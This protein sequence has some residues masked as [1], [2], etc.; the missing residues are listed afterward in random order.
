MARANQLFLKI[1]AGLQPP[2]SGLVDMSKETTMGYLPQQMR[3]DDTTTVMNETITAFSE[4]IGL[5]EEIEFCST[6]I[7]RRDDYESVEYL[8]VM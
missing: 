7:A 4:L 5:S 6:E 2:T 1:I 3:V 8:K